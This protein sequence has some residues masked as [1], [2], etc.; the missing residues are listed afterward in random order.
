MRKESTEKDG[1]QRC[2]ISHSEQNVSVSGQVEQ[3]YQ[4][5]EDRMETGNESLKSQ[6]VIAVSQR[7]WS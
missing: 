4:N 5:D 3:G 1:A 6:Q 2:S 7:Y